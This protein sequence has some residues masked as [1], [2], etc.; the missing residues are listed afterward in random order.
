MAVAFGNHPHAAERLKQ[1]IS[2][3]SPAMRQTIYRRLAPW[4]QSLFPGLVD[5]SSEGVV[6]PAMDEVA[7]RLIREATR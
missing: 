3:A 2:A 5:S 4:Q 7:E 1:L 6:A